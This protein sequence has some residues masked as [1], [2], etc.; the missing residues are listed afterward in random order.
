[1]SKPLSQVQRIVQ[2]LK[3]NEGRGYTAREIAISITDR[4]TDEYELKRRHHDSPEEK[5]FITQVVA[6]IG[7]Q[8][9]RIKKSSGNKVS[10]VD[11]PRPRRYGYNLVDGAPS[12]DLDPAKTGEPSATLKKKKETIFTEHELYPML[13]SYLNSELGLFS[14]R[15]DEKR[16]RNNRGENGNQWLHP[17]IVSMEPVDA[18]WDVLVK[19]CANNCGTQRARLWS[20]EVK[21][22]LTSSDLRKSFF[23]AVSNSSWANEGYLV[24][25][26][27]ASPQVEKEL[28]MLSALH[29]IGFILLN[30]DNPSESEV[31]LPALSKTNV[32]WQSV[33][34]IVV[35]N[36]D[37]RDYIELVSMF[38]QTGKLRP[39][40]WNK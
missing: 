13:I 7:S 4:Y 36:S 29:G 38:C 2:F 30:V 16:S 19:D 27:I 9:D 5:D 37:F 35:E 39:G 17:D 18:G 20:F 23:Q 14:Q 3:E 6:E 10:W 21:K 1:M 11:R 24:A 22:E 31:M 33:N 28:R 8:K 34:R 12:S 25:A 26:K 40:E 15:I 32:D